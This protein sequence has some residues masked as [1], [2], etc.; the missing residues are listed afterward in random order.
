M[1]L[2]RVLFMSE[3]IKQMV[4]RVRK[5][6]VYNHCNFHG[7]I[8]RW[9]NGKCARCVHSKECGRIYPLEECEKHL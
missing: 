6:P 1:S 5:D 9:I 2:L 3:T 4:E 8:Q 7:V